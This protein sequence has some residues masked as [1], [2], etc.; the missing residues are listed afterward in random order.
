MCISFSK[1]VDYFCFNFKYF[2]ICFENMLKF[3]VVL[4][5]YIS[6]NSE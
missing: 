6:K 2:N 3:I 5:Y 4:G 1:M